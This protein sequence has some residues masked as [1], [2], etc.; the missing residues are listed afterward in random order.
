VGELSPPLNPPIA[1]TDSPVL[2]SRLLAVCEPTVAAA[3]RL[4]V[5]FSRVSSF[6]LDWFRPPGP[7]R[8]PGKPW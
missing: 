6:A 5:A 7:P 4:S 8:P 3:Q 2:S 1:I